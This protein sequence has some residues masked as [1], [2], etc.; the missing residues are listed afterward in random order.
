[1]QKEVSRRN[2]DLIMVRQQTTRFGHVDILVIVI[3]YMFVIHSKHIHI[4][5]TILVKYG[6]SG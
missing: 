5:G 6:R 4:L 2:V 3:K 1:M